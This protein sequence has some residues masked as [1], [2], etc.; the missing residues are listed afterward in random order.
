MA[1]DGMRL[2]SDGRLVFDFWKQIE[3]GNVFESF[4]NQQV[5]TGNRRYFRDKL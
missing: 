3:E 5:A 2:F 4:T 1:D